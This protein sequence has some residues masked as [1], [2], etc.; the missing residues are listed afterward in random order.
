MPPTTAR[1]LLPKPLDPMTPLSICSRS[2]LSKDGVR[3]VDGDDRRTTTAFSSTSPTDRNWSW[4]DLQWD[5]GAPVSALTFNEN[6]D[7]LT[8]TADLSAPNATWLSGCPMWT[9]TQSTTT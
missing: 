3:T 7:Q 6:A 2:R 9:T 4:G 8:I 1:P 5:Y